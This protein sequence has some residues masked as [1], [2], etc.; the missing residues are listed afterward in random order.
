M[1]KSISLVLAFIMVLALAISVAAAPDAPEAVDGNGATV[2]A[3]VDKLSGSENELCI[4]IIPLEG[5]PISQLFSINNN[6]E[7]I[8]DLGNGYT[9]F[10]DTKGNTQI[11]AC[12][13]VS[14][15]EV[16]QTYNVTFSAAGDTFTDGNRDSVTV[17]VED[18]EKVARKFVNGRSNASQVGWYTENGEKFDFNTPITEDTVLTLKWLFNPTASPESGDLEAGDIITLSCATE[19]AS[20]EYI[21]GLGLTY[22]PCEGEITISEED[23]NADG[24]FTLF[25]RSIYDGTKS[26]VVRFYYTRTPVPAEM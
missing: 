2:I 12:Y 10:V 14:V 9:V 18:G 4:T 26:A 21:I 17:Q 23:F 3:T 25:V 13:F 8:F 15:P 5:E 11:R 22:T 24:K 19:G 1:K 20:Y 7:C 16:P 6:S